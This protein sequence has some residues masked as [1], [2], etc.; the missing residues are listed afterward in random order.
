MSAVHAGEAFRAEIMSQH[1]DVAVIRDG[2]GRIVGSCALL[3]GRRF[4]PRALDRIE[5]M[6][7][8]LATPTQAGRDWLAAEMAARQ[9]SVDA[10]ERAALGIAPTTTEDGR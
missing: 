3:D 8:D 10:H 5:A 7:R 6:A 4:T 1:G 2:H 9:S